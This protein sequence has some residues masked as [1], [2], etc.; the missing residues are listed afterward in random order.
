LRPQQ[1]DGSLL[2]TFRA[3]VRRH[4][5]SALIPSNNKSIITAPQHNPLIWIATTKI[6]QTRNKYDIARKTSARGSNSFFSRLG[7][8]F[9]TETT[10]PRPYEALS[11]TKTLQQQSIKSQCTK[12]WKTEKLEGTTKYDWCA[13][14][15][16]QSILQVV[17]QLG[18]IAV[19]SI[20]LTC[21]RSR[22]FV[23][24]RIGLLD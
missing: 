9:V 8:S 2:L 24:A 6:G 20:L 5:L 21:F 18:S 4:L 12:R 7:S 17:Q 16:P 22:C 3:A 14:R 23:G 19:Q 11:R 13:A 15:F 10:F 1:R